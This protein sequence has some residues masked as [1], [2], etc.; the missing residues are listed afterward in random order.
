MIALLAATRSLPI[1]RPW[2]A[3]SLSRILL[4]WRAFLPYTNFAVLDVTPI[5]ALAPRSHRTCR[6]FRWWVNERENRCFGVNAVGLERQGFGA[7]RIEIIKR[8]YRL[9]LR[10]K[11][12]TAQ[13]VE[14]MRATLDGSPTWRS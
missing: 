14:E 9:L 3:T 2:R 8:A 4:R 7:E 13:A 12:N 1:A 5:S 11:L 10:S 6:L